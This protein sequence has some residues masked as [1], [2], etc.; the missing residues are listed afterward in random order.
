MGREDFATFE[1][2]L[3]GHADEPVSSTLAREQVDKYVAAVEEKN[4][5]FCDEDAA[6]KSEWGG[7]I[8][9]PTGATMYGRKAGGGPRKVPAGGV[10]A[11]Q[12][13]EFHH[14]ARVGDTLTCQTTIIDKYIKRERKYVVQETVTRNQDGQ[15]ICVARGTSIRPV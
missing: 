15:I 12:Y 3:V 5:L 6:K 11:K 9:P 8:A 14:P 10:H 2:V 7:L 1:E 4:P 13:Y